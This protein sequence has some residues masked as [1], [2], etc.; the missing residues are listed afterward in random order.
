M[1]GF[2]E[3]GKVELI[4]VLAKVLDTEIDAVQKST[5]MKVKKKQGM[6]AY[7]RSAF[8]NKLKKLET[9]LF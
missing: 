4:E 5:S 7:Y 3:N 8:R 9:S 1:N 2:H 6:I